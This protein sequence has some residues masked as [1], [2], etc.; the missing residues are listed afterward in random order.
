MN[1]NEKAKIMFHALKTEY[2]ILSESGDS[3]AAQAIANF[4]NT[5]SHESAARLYNIIEAERNA[6]K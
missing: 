4:I 5:A 3:A 1:R 2:K 6:T